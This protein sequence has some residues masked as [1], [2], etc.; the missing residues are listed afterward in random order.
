MIRHIVLF[1]AKDNA[2]IEQMID[3]LSVLTAIPHAHRLEVARNRKTDQFGND[4]DV[5]LYGEFDD[6]TK[7]AAFKAA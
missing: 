6:E 1:I 5:I 2:S 4:I 3:S 7:L